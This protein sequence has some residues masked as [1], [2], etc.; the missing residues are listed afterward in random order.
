[1][2]AGL[3]VDTILV[4]SNN[5]DFP[6]INAHHVVDAEGNRLDTLLSGLGVTKV[7]R[8]PTGETHEDITSPSTDTI[9]LEETSVD[10]IY[11]RWIYDSENSEW[12]SLGNAEMQ[13]GNYVTT[14]MLATALA[15]K[16]DKLT[17]GRNI[18]ITDEAEISAR[19]GVDFAQGAFE[20]DA[21]TGNL[22]FTP[23]D[24]EATTSDFSL[25]ENGHLILNVEM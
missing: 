15:T 6:L 3:Q 19:G 7:K 14:E 13:L 11:E 1:M 2:A 20:I 12:V 22:M 25:D 24:A 23:N 8:I 4:P 5:A 21:N 17:A 16:Q 10:N 9:Y 18:V